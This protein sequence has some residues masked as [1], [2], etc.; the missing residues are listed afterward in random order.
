MK[1]S[2][3]ALPT[4]ATPS[5]GRARSNHSY[6]TLPD[7]NRPAYPRMPSE[8]TRRPDRLLSIPETAEQLGISEKGVR[9]AIQRG[10]LAAHRIGW[11]LRIS[12]E[13]LAAFVAVRRMRA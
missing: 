6:E 9:R 7:G 13:D 11:L 5:T 1:K 2:R 8:R 4:S 10:D 12:D 3:A